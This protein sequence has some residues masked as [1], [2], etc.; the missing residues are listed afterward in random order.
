MT[1]STSRPQTPNFA[2]RSSG[3]SAQTPPPKSAS[4]LVSPSARPTYTSLKPKSN[5]EWNIDDEDEDDGNEIADTTIY[6]DGIDEDEFGLPTLSTARRKAKR[7]PND[8][9]Y[10]PGGNRTNGGAS[11]AP[12]QPISSGRERSN[13][14]DIAEV[15]GSPAYPTAN[16][17]EGKILRPQYKEILRGMYSFYL[18]VRNLLRPTPRSC[19][20]SS[21]N[22][23]SSV[24]PQCYSKSIGSPLDPNYQNQQV[25]ANTASELHIAR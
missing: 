25:Q 16:K 3:R 8:K 1:P 13:S 19:K 5:N 12:L 17:S 9:A 4:A 2:H 6:D 21:S 15:R 18:Q 24:T 11:L 23:P 22:Y 20:F 14:S 7:I 10:D